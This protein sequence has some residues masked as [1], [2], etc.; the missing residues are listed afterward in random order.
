M[1]GRKQNQ[2]HCPDPYKKCANAL[3]YGGW[4]TC[5][6]SY[7]IS[8]SIYLYQD[9]LVSNAKMLATRILSLAAIATA[10]TIQ[11]DVGK[12]GLTFS[13]DSVTAA[14]GDIVEFHFV[15]GYH[16][17][18]KG[19]FDKPCT[20]V[21]GGFASTTEAGSA[22]NVGCSQI[23]QPCCWSCQRYLSHANTCNQKNIFRVTI[24]DT[25][26]IYYYCSV[27]AHCPNGMVAAINPAVDKTV[28]AFK[29]AAKG[30][31]ATRPVG[32]PYGGE[33]TTSA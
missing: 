16:D 26:P 2:G 8:D 12:G 28:A 1:P 21:A 24:N 3:M 4:S 31:A 25:Q 27:G 14:K 29:A 11:I 13:P 33:M 9:T 17:A 5:E 18:V 23:M 32:A 30:K 15:G 7:T 22:T 10:A 20:P 6:P 19:D